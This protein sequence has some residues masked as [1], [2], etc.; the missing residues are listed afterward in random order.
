MRPPITLHLVLPAHV[1]SLIASLG[2]LG[3]AF[4][5]EKDEASP[6]R[7]PD[8]VRIAVVRSFFRDIPE[9]LIQ[10]LIEPF[11]ALMMAQTGVK[12]DIVPTQDSVKLAQGLAENKIHV[13][14]FQGFE[15]AW[16][17]QTSP[18]LQPLM[19]AIHQRPDIRA[20]LMARADNPI[21]S[22]ADVKGKSGALPLMTQEYCR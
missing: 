4:A 14:L 15:F 11:R 10:H 21:Q 5:D 7:P 1:L 19:I 3:P 6:T 22:F 8:V 12:S 17:K 20:C 9:P 16:A 13:V 18:E 2:L